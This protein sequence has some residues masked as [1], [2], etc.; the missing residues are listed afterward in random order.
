MPLDDIVARLR[1]SGHKV[2]PQRIT[3][4]KLIIESS[5]L[6]TPSALYEKV[7]Q[8]YPEVGEVTVYRTLSI[9][10]DLGLVCVVH[11]CDN[12]HSY[13]IRPPGHHDHLIC[14]ECGKVINF[15]DCNVSELEKRLMEET[16]YIINEHRLDFYG[17]CHDCRKVN[18]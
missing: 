17:K 1:Q 12:V 18:R 14:S 9:L 8:L 13:T 3:I 2:T 16:G 11:T 4:I 5:E 10:S 15:T 7:H 6:L